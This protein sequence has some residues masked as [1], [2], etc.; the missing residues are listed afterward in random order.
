MIF[1]LIG[2]ALVALIAFAL[3]QGSSLQ[4]ILIEKTITINAP[5]EKVFDLVKYLKNFPKWSPFLVQD[6]S[7]KYEVK[8]I[9]GAV[10][11][12]YYWE[13]NKGKD[14]GYQEIVKIKEQTFIGKKCD[15]QKPFVAQPTFEYYFSNNGNTVEVKEVFQLQ[16]GLINAV[17]LWI[18]GAKAAMEKTNQ[19]GLDLLK[20]AAEN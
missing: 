8:G 2:I 18:F 16:S 9:D 6:P 15:I 4:K 7:Q 10:G 1:T 19:Q 13:G 20:K 14:L 3:Y 11:A 17:F 12:Q 5:K